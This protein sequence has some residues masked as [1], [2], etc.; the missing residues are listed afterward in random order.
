[1]LA[2]ARNKAFLHHWRQLSIQLLVNRSR[3][4]SREWNEWKHSEERTVFLQ[5][6]ERMLV[7]GYT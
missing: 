6:N 4:Y 7:R 3:H 2:V 1:M 5:R